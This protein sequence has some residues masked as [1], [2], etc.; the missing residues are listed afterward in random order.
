MAVV[1][2]LLTTAF[3][4][5]NLMLQPESLFAN[6]SQAAF[7]IGALISLASL[8]E[9]SGLVGPTGGL[10]VRYA[11]RCGFLERWGRKGRRNLLIITLIWTSKAVTCV[12][13]LLVYDGTSSW[14]SVC[15]ALVSWLQAGFY[16]A[17][18]HFAFQLVLFLQLMLDGFSVKFYTSLDMTTGAA[19]WNIVQ[20]ILR[21][22]STTIETSFLAVQTSAFVAFLCITAQML[23]IIMTQTGDELYKS[24]TCTLLDIPTL[25]MA[26]SALVLFAD[27]AAVSEKCTRVPPV[28]NSLLVDPGSAVTSR[29]HSFV[30]F[31]SN[32]DAGF[33]VKGN[34]LNS[35]VLMNYCYLCG[36]IICGIFTTA[37]SMSRSK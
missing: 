26:L 10:L 4:V 16:L 11:S 25:I 1:A 9:V 32:S 14:L 13:H 35:M 7:S 28:V 30:S 33:Y 8:N 37:L 36:A 6:F 20:S 17:I 34:R 31:I 18:I 21:R 3:S 24:W 12:L 27:A 19:S 22:V 15:I 29:H 23:R 5:C 2:L